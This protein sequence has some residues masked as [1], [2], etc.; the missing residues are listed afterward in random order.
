MPLVL[1]PLSQ[2]YLGTILALLVTAGL[3]GGV[4]ARAAPPSH[5]ALSG[6]FTV[7]GA[8]LAMVFL[9]L[10]SALVL[11][12]GLRADDSAGTYLTLV[13]AWAALCSLGGPLILA[14]EIGRA[15]CRGEVDT[16]T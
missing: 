6:G 16:R 1:L 8:F 2:Y 14:L 13:V 9:C 11:A 15:S 10:Q 3:V 7:A 5:R 12:E 4:V